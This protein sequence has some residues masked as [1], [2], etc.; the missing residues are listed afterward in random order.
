MKEEVF[1]FDVDGTLTEPRSIINPDFESYMLEF[2]KSNDVYLV[3]GSDRKKTFEQIGPN[4]YDAVKGIWQCNGNEYWEGNRR[5]SKTDYKPDYDFKHFLTQIVH[6]SKYPIKV[7]DHIELRTGMVNFSVVGR[8]ANKDQR[9]AYYKW[10]CKNRERIDIADQINRSYKD[11]HA[12]IGGM[13]S[14]DISPKGNNK[15][16]VANHLNKEYKYIRFFGDKCEVGGNDYPIALTIELA[17]MGEVYRVSDWKDTRA[18]LQ[19]W[20]RMKPYF[21]K[22]GITKQENYNGE[23]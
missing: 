12:T 7:G 15:S 22:H 11:L 23:V 9:E 5:V 16:Q 3:S 13:I 4:L 6:R 19:S 21:E 1:V 17:K 10:D 2:C 20:E 14:I 18:L 8:A